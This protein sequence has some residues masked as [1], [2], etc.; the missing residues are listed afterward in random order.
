M[1]P[2]TSYVRT[3]VSFR[4]TEVSRHIYRMRHHSLHAWADFQNSHDICSH[5]GGC[6]YLPGKVSIDLN[7]FQR[8]RFGHQLQ[9]GL[10][11]R[12]GRETE[13]RKSIARRC[14][15]VSSCV[16]VTCRIYGRYQEYTFFFF[17][18]LL[19]VC[20][21]WCRKEKTRKWFAR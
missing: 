2:R 19:S 20:V 21:R 4:N 14:G 1:A 16:Q 17:L 18:S 5:R 13:L 15:V 3:Y 7:V 11:L 12:C 8:H 6:Q 9:S 10:S